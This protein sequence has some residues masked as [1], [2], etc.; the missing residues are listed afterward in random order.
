MPCSGPM[1]AET[2]MTF[3]VVRQTVRYV[4]YETDDTMLSLLFLIMARKCGGDREKNS[5]QTRRIKK[6]MRLVRGTAKISATGRTVTCHWHILLTTQFLQDLCYRLRSL[7]MGYLIFSLSVTL[8]NFNFFFIFPFFRIFLL[9]D[10][11][12]T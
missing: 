6:E 12:F 3:V 5:L 10:I 2:F 8:T 4:A 1:S 11:Y 9:F 7:N